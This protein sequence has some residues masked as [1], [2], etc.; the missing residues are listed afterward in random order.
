MAEW[1]TAEA[2]PEQPV[3]SPSHSSQ[4]MWLLRLAVCLSNL[5]L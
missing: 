3:S 2:Q 5:Y 1:R 4:L